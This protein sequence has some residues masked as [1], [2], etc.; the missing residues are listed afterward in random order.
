MREHYLFIYKDFIYLLSREREGG[1][2]REGEK[3]WC[4][5][6]IDWSPLVR[7][8]TP[9]QTRNPGTCPDWES[10]KQPFVLLDNIQPT[11]SYWSGQR[12]FKKINK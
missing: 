9:D 11:D 1:G 4:E 10:N 6:N 7:A 12:A 2:E 8:P 3:H 5:R